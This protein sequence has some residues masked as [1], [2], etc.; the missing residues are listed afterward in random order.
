V[1]EFFLFRQYLPLEGELK[2]EVMQFSISAE[3]PRKAFGPA[4]EDLE[5]K[6]DKSLV[7]FFLYH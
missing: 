7:G 3:P 4:Y 6:A 1:S 5:G 2:R